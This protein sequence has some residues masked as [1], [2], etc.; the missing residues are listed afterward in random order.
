[1]K[2][3]AKKVFGALFAV[4][5]IFSSNSMSALAAEGVEELTMQQGVVAEETVTGS[6]YEG[7]YNVKD[8][9]L[10][11]ANAITS[12]SLDVSK[13][14]GIVIHV[15]TTCNFTASKVGIK[16]LAVQQKVWYGWKDV[17][18]MSNDYA[19]STWSYN[20]STTYSGAVSGE[21]YRVVCTH[22]AI[23]SN[24]VEHAQYNETGSFVY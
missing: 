1:M 6:V 11:R 8:A 16:N 14:S 10:V 17:A 2:T 22:Y 12:K 5:L 18:T 24:G 15:T 13:S 4:T 3:I 19:S 9:A 21:T 7:I 23:E 20:A